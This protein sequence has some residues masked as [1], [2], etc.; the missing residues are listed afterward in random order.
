[1]KPCVIICLCR[2]RWLCS[3]RI[4]QSHLHSNRETSEGAELILPRC[5]TIVAFEQKTFDDFREHFKAWNKVNT[6]EITIMSR[7]I[8]CSFNCLHLF[9]LSLNLARC[10]KSRF[11]QLHADPQINSS[12]FS[13]TSL[14]SFHVL[15]LIFPGVNIKRLHLKSRSSSIVKIG[16]VRIEVKKGDITNETVRGIVNTT[17]RDMSLRGGL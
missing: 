9:F 10:L 11:G 16:S 6:D 14:T 12:S 17:N 8:F 13:N 1:M 3:E 5:I 4:N 15:V 7:F 2:T